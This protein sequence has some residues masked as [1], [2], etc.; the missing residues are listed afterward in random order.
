MLSNDIYSSRRIIGT[1]IP[2]YVERAE[3]QKFKN[4]LPKFKLPH[5]KGISKKKLMI[6]ES[7]IDLRNIKASLQTICSPVVDTVFEI[8]IFASQLGYGLESEIY[9]KEIEFINLGEDFKSGSKF[10]NGKVFR[11]GAD[12]GTEQINYGY[13]SRKM[14]KVMMSIEK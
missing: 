13:E 6:I 2:S 7:L 12:Q 14:R 4:H 9:S 5:K 3:E 1:Q 11:R 8:K 10:I